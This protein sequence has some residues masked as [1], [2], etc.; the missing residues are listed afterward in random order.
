MSDY[1]DNKIEEFFDQLQKVIDQTQN[2]KRTF[3]LCKETGIQFSGWGNENWQGICG[4]FSNDETY[5][6]RLWLLEFVTFNA[7]LTTKK[8]PEDGPSIAK[9]DITKTRL[10]TFW[11]GSTSDHQWTLSEHKIFLEQTLEVTTTCWWWPSTFIWKESASWNTQTQV[12]PGKAER[13]QFV[14][15][16]QSYD[17][18]EVTISHHHEKCR[19]TQGFNGH[20]PEHSSDWNSLW[21]PWQILSGKKKN[22]TKNSG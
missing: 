22:K 19:C 14:G 16:L 8:H 13:S 12:W 20:H 17:R 7:H 1:D 2:I 15:N 10:I 21:D 9:M 11:W 4:P 3:L 18:Q 6:R 5:V